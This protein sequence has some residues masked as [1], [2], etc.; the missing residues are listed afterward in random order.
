MLYMDSPQ[1]LSAEIEAGLYSAMQKS[2][3]DIEDKYRELLLDTVYADN[4][5]YYV[6][7]YEM[8][9]AV[10]SEITFGNDHPYDVTVYI[11]SSKMTTSQQ[12]FQ[13]QKRDSRTGKIVTTTV[14]CG[15]HTDNIGNDVREEVIGYV[16]GGSDPSTPYAYTRHGKRGGLHKYPGHEDTNLTDT[17]Y[18]WVFY[19]YFP[20]LLENTF[21]LADGNKIS[22]Y[23]KQ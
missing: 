21:P 5:K 2:G 16:L 8:L 20:N 7:T 3:N 17:M 13:M 23:R 18:D 22:I 1:E 19:E 15:V 6:R 14:M 9:D 11:D 4:P 10:S 12:P